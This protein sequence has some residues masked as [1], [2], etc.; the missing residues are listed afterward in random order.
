MNLRARAEAAQR[1]LD[2]GTL[3]RIAQAALAAGASWELA[4]QLPNHGQPF[5]A[6]IAAVIALGAE[7]GRRGKQAIRMMIGV[8]VGIVIGA[9]VLSLGGAGWW[10]LV[11]GAGISLVLTT[12]AGA[13][14]IVRNQAAASAVLVLAL[15]RPGSCLALQ[16]LEDALIGGAVAVVLAQLLFPLDPVEHVL[17]EIGLLREQTAGAL[18]RLAAALETRDVDRARAALEGIDSVD[19]R[20]VED[21][22]ALAREVVRRAPRRRP[23][24]DVLEQLGLAAHELN[25]A[26]A[27]GH[28][29]A[30]GAVRLLEADAAPVGEAAEVVR[31][32]AGAVRATDEKE[33]R[34]WSR[35]ID[36][37]VDRLQ[38]Q[39]SLGAEVLAV[40]ARDVAGHALRAAHALAV[41][42]APGR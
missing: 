37:A 38:A 5:F 1:N 33:S 10:Q 3:W 19:E 18:D 39:G 7:R 35:R 26:A 28:A 12:A 8:A 14:L 34:E 22:L 31:A 27:D 15:H 42:S 24:R 9:A 2:R 21:A 41:A 11:L 29:V 20:R 36:P 25:A 23:Q 6:P 13:T 17:D 30:T 40:G 32:L 16:R 4:L